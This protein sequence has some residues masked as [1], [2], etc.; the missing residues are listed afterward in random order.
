MTHDA[1]IAF[2][3]GKGS[4]VTVNPTTADYWLKS[5]LYLAA[6]NMARFD[7]STAATASAKSISSFTG[8]FF[9]GPASAGI[10][11]A[12]QGRSP[13]NAVVVPSRDVRAMGHEELAADAASY[14]DCFF[15][16]VCKAAL[17]K[18]FVKLKPPETTPIIP[19]GNATQF[20]Q[21]V[22]A[23][24]R[25]IRAMR[26][27]WAVVGGEDS[28]GNTDRLGTFK[29]FLQLCLEQGNFP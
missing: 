13:S 16:P 23:L 27:Q 21:P 11:V 19:I 10:G 18:E 22:R 1:L 25:R 3:A 29:G 6:V 20:D 8:L 15:D 12:M 5:P 28:A 26:H 9:V 2:A 14:I 4:D 17:D 24:T 7:L